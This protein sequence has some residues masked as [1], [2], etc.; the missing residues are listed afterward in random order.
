M[1]TSGKYEGPLSV[2]KII[3]WTGFLLLLVKIIAD[4]FDL[5]EKIYPKPTQEQKEADLIKFAKETRAQQMKQVM[6]S[7]CIEGNCDNGDGTWVYANGTVYKG[8]FVNQRIDGFGVIV[9][10]PNAHPSIEFYIGNFIVGFPNGSGYI[11]YENG[12]VYRGEV[13]AN[14]MRHGKGLLY[15]RAESVGQEGSWNEN[16][17][18][19]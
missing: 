15:D 9:F 1:S 2:Q 14:Y 10:A 17:L 12:S 4:P 5:I 6:K 16:A 11:S 7:G 18:I 13:N 3:F 8:T 19:E